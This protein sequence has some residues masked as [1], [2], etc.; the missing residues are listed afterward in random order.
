MELIPYFF[1]R[2]RQQTQQKLMLARNKQYCQ[3]LQKRLNLID[4]LAS[5][6]CTVGDALFE[7][8]YMLGEAEHDRDEISWRERQQRHAANERVAIIHDL[9]QHLADWL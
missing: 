9:Y 1:A 8:Q 4:E 6:V 7:L 3:Q 5:H 2:E